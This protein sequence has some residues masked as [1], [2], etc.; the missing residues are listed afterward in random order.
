ML[1]DFDENDVLKL[2][3]GNEDTSPEIWS[4]DGTEP[5]YPEFP[6]VVDIMADYALLIWKSSDNSQSTFTGKVSRI[7]VGTAEEPETYD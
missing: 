6:Q 3:A 7:E 5:A 1:K 4:F 2:F